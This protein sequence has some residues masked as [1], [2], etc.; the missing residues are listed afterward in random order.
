[1]DMEEVVAAFRAGIRGEPVELTEPQPAKQ[2]D[3]YWWGRAGHLLHQ[4]QSDDAA[5]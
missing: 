4:D 1:V 3:G 5:S 2:C